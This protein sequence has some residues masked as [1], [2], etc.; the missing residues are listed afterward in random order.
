VRSFEKVMMSPNTPENDRLE[1]L[2]RRW[3]A[4][5]AAA[6]QPVG[7]PPASLAVRPP[8]S[9]FRRYAPLAA[10]A[11]LLAVAT[12]LYLASPSATD[13]PSE[14]ALDSA[15]LSPQLADAR[16]ALSDLQAESAARESS[17]AA[18]VDRLRQEL[19]LARQ[20][21]AAEAALAAQ[22]WRDAVAGLKATADGLAD[23]I[24]VRDSS[25]LLLQ[26]ELA[27]GDRSRKTL[28]DQCMQLAGDVLKL[29]ERLAAADAARLDAEARLTAAEAHATEL[30]ALLPSPRAPAP[31]NAVIPAHNVTAYG[32]LAALKEK[33]RQNQLL[34]RA[35]QLRPR[36]TDADVRRLMD[37]EE[38]LLTRL[39]LLDAGNLVER[40]AF[41]ASLRNTEIGRRTAEV[42]QKSSPEPDVRAWLT[43]SQTLLAGAERAF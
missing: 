4:E 6:G 18:D 35:A 37:A 11:V 7:R 42:L 28:E 29:R 8:A 26:S 17:L 31:A 41:L 9:W 12:G 36:V 34:R 1:R 16:K 40:D 5:E 3:G 21:Q 32:A 25:L 38:A 33:A 24:R 20:Q 22:P 39:D 10:A 15:A 30:A 23:Q 19:V 43:E 14:A 27:K 13:R 2:L